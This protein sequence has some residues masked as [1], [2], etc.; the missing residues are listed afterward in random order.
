MCPASFPVPCCLPRYPDGSASAS[1][2]SRPA[3]ALLA[4]R[5]AGSLSRAPAVV[6]DKVGRVDVAVTIDAEAVRVVE[7]VGAEAGDEFAAW[8]EFLDRIERR[9]GT[10]GGAA[11]VEHPDALAVFV[12]FYADRRS[13]LAAGGEL[14]PVLLQAVRIGRGVGV[15][16]RLRVSPLSR[17]RDRRHRGDPE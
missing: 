16:I 4:L 5:P 17:H 6:G 3:Q 2:L 14:R 7:E 15:G 12:S 11:A 1:L 9:V 10:R 8:I 13:H